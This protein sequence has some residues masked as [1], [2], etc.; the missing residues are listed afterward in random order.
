MRFSKG[1]WQWQENVTPHL[2]ARL[3]TYRREP[4]VLTLQVADQASPHSRLEAV[5]LKIKVTSPLPNVLRVQAVHF[6]RT[7]RGDVKFPLDYAREAP[8]THSGR[9]GERSDLYQRPDPP[10]G[11]KNDAVPDVL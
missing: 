9:D 8:D 6:T 5:V 4:G 7:E 1:N 3:L 11:H 2:A 10:A